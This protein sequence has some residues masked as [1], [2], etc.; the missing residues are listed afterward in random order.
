[1]KYLYIILFTAM[2]NHAI[3]QA[4]LLGYN[5]VRARIDPNGCL[6][7]EASA[8]RASYEVPKTF[9]GSGPDVIYN[10][11]FWVGARDQ[12]GTARVCANKFIND[13]KDFRKGPVADN[14]NDLSFISKYDR[15]YSISKSEIE[16]HQLNWNSPNYTV[17][18][19]IL[20]WPG[21]GDVAN[22]EASIL[23][24]FVD[25]NNNGIYEPLL[26]DYPLIR[27][28]RTAFFIMNDNDGTHALSGG[29]NLNM[30]YHFM[31]Y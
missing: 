8:N 25:Y 7:S 16:S 31:L 1:M 17:P 3:T 13:A 12:N 11:A 15:V 29:L 22:G 19:N 26:G 23:A 9:D 24:P 27:G 6:F 30:E 2:S 14:Y 10:S 18:T 4:I 21:N 20:E 28:D 5:N